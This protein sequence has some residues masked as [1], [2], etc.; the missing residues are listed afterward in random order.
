MK[1][2][3]AANVTVLVSALVMVLV[4]RPRSHGQSRLPRD[5]SQ[6]LLVTLRNVYIEMVEGEIGGKPR[7][8]NEE[9][10]LVVIQNQCLGTVCSG[11]GRG[12]RR[13]LVPSFFLVP[14]LAKR[15]IEQCLTMRARKGG[16]RMNRMV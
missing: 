3:A 7:S 1:Y 15:T 13:G 16:R 4:T 9:A 14:S 2:Q 8:A 10:F 6:G 11:L 5:Q 12:P